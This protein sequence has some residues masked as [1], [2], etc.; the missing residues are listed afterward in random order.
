MN[1]EP[2]VEP[3]AILPGVKNGVPGAHVGQIGDV[4]VHSNIIIYGALQ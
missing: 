1:V 3:A 4:L 2:A